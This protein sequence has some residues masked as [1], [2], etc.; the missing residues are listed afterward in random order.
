MVLRE[1]HLGA[2][3][4]LVEGESVSQGRYRAQYP[5][6]LGTPLQPV[7]NPGINTEQRCFYKRIMSTSNQMPMPASRTVYASDLGRLGNAFRV[8]HDCKCAC[9]GYQCGAKRGF[10]SSGRYRPRCIS[11]RPH[12]VVRYVVRWRQDSR[13]TSKRSSTNEV[14]RWPSTPYRLGACRVP[15]S[16]ERRRGC[17]RTAAWVDRGLTGRWR[18]LMGLTRPD[19]IDSSAFRPQARLAVLPSQPWSGRTPVARFRATVQQ[20]LAARSSILPSARATGS[21][22]R[23]ARWVAAARSLSV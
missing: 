18:R 15:G 8:R 4:G 13:L 6:N 19:R 7:C 2:R 17:P 3:A 9:L 5:G 1:S 21:A 16:V 20:C 11:D 12:H 23:H 14:R 22:S 10:D